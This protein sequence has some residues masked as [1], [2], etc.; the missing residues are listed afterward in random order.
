MELPSAKRFYDR[1][2]LVYDAIADVSEHRAREKG[3]DLLSIQPGETV[4]EIGFGTGYS[5]VQLAEAVTTQGQVLGIDISTGMREVARGRLDD[6]RLTSRVELTVAEVP[7]LP[8]DDASVNAVS[9]SFTL[10][11]F[12]LDLIP[13]VLAE[14]RRVL[15]PTGRL[16]LVGMTTQGPDHK[17]SLLERGYRWAHHHFPHIIDCQPIDAVQ[18]LEQ[19]GF[20]I[21]A[22]TDMEIWTIPVIAL[23]ADV[24]R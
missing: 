10:E 22:Q 21:T 16:G 12:P 5:L 3:L 7:P 19:A 15:K 14:I 2:S 8:Y 23:V 9:M 4:L 17:G 1:I 18:F 24:S 13:T 6:A 11:L 20:R